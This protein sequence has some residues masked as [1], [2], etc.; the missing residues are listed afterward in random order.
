MINICPRCGEIVRLEPGAIRSPKPPP[1]KEEI[2]A[3]KLREKL[4]DFYCAR[5]WKEAC[6]DKAF[7]K[8]FLPERYI[9]KDSKKRKTKGY[10][11]S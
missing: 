1:S 9:E 7:A 3:E 5:C 6:K 10:V 2:V 4:F 8:E 11:K